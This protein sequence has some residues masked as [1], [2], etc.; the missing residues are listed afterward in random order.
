MRELFCR[1]GSGSLQN[2]SPCFNGVYV[3]RLIL[4]DCAKD[5]LNVIQGSNIAGGRR[6]STAADILVHSRVVIQEFRD[7]SHLPRYRLVS[8]LRLDSEGLF[9]SAPSNLLDIRWVGGRQGGWW[10]SWRV[11]LIGVAVG[12]IAAIQTARR[13]R[14]YSVDGMKV[15]FD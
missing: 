9:N 8:L 2:C 15:A 1:T 10:R 13:L 14:P 5:I 11:F 6:V 3:H 4:V 7:G 12:L